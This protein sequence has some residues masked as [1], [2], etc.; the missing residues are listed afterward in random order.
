MKTEKLLLGR[1]TDKGKVKKREFS[2]Y[3]KLDIKF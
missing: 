3:I 2:D 1:I